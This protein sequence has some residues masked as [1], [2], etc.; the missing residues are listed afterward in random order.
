M[1]SATGIIPESKSNMQPMFDVSLDDKET[2]GFQVRSLGSELHTNKQYVNYKFE[3]VTPAGITFEFQDR[4]SNIEHFFRGLK[5]SL[6][7]KHP[8]LVQSFP[9]MPKK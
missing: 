8:E 1:V 5:S 2:T 7:P 9:E 3:I 6:R 4:Y